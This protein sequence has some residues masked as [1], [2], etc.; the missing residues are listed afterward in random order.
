LRSKISVR[1]DIRH[2]NSKTRRKREKKR[3]KKMARIRESRVHDRQKVGKKGGGYDQF[4]SINSKL[5][6]VCRNGEKRSRRSG[7]LLERT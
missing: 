2:R 6:R 4:G 7:N 5:S 1:R 3:G